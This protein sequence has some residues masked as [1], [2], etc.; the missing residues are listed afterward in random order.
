MHNRCHALSCN[1]IVYH[2]VH[3]GMTMNYLFL[4]INISLSMMYQLPDNI[5]VA[6]LD[7][8]D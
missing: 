7:S 8:K 3:W 4:N 1:F 5:S 2:N 6:L